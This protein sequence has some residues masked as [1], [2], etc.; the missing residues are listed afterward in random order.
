MDA[1]ERLFAET[2]TCKG[3]TV[4]DAFAEEP[5]ASRACLSAAARREWLFRDFGTPIRYSLAWWLQRC[6][7]LFRH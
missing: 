4:M 2:A 7:Y 6:H 5:F 3:H 1:W